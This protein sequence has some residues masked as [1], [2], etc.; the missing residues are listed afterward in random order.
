M[1]GKSHKSEYVILAVLAV[2]SAVVILGLLAV[3]WLRQGED[4]GFWARTTRSTNGEGTIVSYTL[5]ERLGIP[6]VRSDRPLLDD[7]LEE[8]DVLFLVEPLFPVQ[9]GE[10]LAV[11][12]W[13]AGGGVLVCTTAGLGFF[14]DEFGIDDLLRQREWSDED[15]DEPWHDTDEERLP[16]PTRVPAQARTYPLA[17]DVSVVHLAG[18]RVL[19]VQ[20]DE[21]TASRERVH[22]LFSDARG[23]RI[24]ARRTGLGWVVVLSDSSFLANG[25][26][27]KKDNAV[28]AVN[29]AAWARSRARGV[30]TAWDEYHYG[31]GERLTGWDVMTG[32]LLGTT[33]GWSILSVAAAGILYL[34]YRGRRFGT[35]RTPTQ[36]RRRSKLEFV[37][38]VGA[39][40]RAARAHRLVFGIVYQ[41][42]RRKAAQHTGL[43]A[44]APPAEIAERLAQRTGTSSHRPADVLRSCETA[45]KGA[46]LSSRQL[47]TLLDQL[48]VIESEI[49]DGH[50]GRK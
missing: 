41:W 47:S 38:A 2:L 12:R 8:M 30:R 7:A 49:D 22:T 19:D 48:A 14:G 27:G 36:V 23:P 3:G 16:G 1:P 9:E 21:T 25:H 39:T 31:F 10:L 33:P 46:S 18:S 26:I 6:H 42:F 17:R 28:L 32:T 4:R 44:T 40:Y 11:K 15:A 43:P 29:L 37:H 24:A 35:R 13:V 50:P 34:V 45:L 5:F 20:D